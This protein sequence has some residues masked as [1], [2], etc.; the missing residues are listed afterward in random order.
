MRKGFFFYLLCLNSF[1]FGQ[2][3]S[4][5]ERAFAFFQAQSPRPEGSEREARAFEYIQGYLEDWGI[6][7]ERQSLDSLE[8]AHSF[9]YN[10]I[11]QL[12]GVAE[13]NFILA[14]KMDSYGEGGDFN[15][16]LALAFLEG[17]RQRPPPLNLTLL[18][19]SAD[20]PERN[21]LGSR[22]FLDQYNYALPT[23]LFYLNLQSLDRLPLLGVSSPGSTTPSWYLEDLRRLLE[24]RKIPYDFVPSELTV[25]KL[26]I[27]TVNRGLGLYLE[28]EIPAL[29]LASGPPG[30]PLPEAEEWL[31]FLEDLMGAYSQG[32]PSN[33][34]QNYLYLPQGEEFYFLSEYRLV[35]IYILLAGFVLFIPFLFQ[36]QV[37]LNLR[38]FRSQLWTIPFWIYLGF[39]FLFFATLMTEEMMT[40]WGS[41]EI[42]RQYPL[43]FFLLKIL[44]TI[45]PFLIFTHPL[46]SLP[47]PSSSTF[48]SYLASL[49]A[50]INLLLISVINLPL[51]IPML[52]SLLF[53]FAFTISPKRW[54]RGLFLFL[55]LLPQIFLVYY[56][57]QENYT[58]IYEQF[59]LSRIGGNWV[60]ALLSFPAIMMLFSL[61]IQRYGIKGSYQEIWVALLT[62]VL[63]ILFLGLALFS[64]TL[65]PFSEEHPHRIY[66]EDFFDLNKDSREV[67]VLGEEAEIGPGSLSYKGTRIPFQG[68]SQEL[69]IKGEIKDYPMTINW[70][71]QEFLE[72]TLVNLRIEIFSPVE[73]L[74]LELLSEEPIILYD[75]PFPYEIQPNLKKGLIYVGLNPPFPLE[76]PLVFAQGTLP[77]LRIIGLRSTADYELTL[78]SPNTEILRQ[79]RIERT[80]NLKDPQGQ[81]GPRETTNP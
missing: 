16:A 69:R 55:H 71:S 48:Y 14:V 50:L 49:G 59:L 32:F 25:N 62:V 68:N 45:I 64:S 24:K 67:R 39:L 61:V 70:Q 75:S 12:P 60:L 77:T 46:R 7:Y 63:T 23:V 65:P 78:Y 20:R 44:L 79:T 54:K 26:G 22:G 80:I 73:E 3:E 38:R 1:L 29:T 28:E 13:A 33:W 42:W 51:G 2:E 36:E 41:Q 57:F 76:L 43:Q 34:E 15:P 81:V 4:L 37:F 35:L 31:A 53:T 9:S 52:G 58:A 30:G 21:F 74:Q 8:G 56:F 11:V 19:T 66:L 18:F 6:D 47:I 5:F 72:R 40:L 10:L 27:P 17:W